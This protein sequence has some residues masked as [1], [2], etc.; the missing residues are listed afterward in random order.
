MDKPKFKMRTVIAAAIGIMSLFLVSCIYFIVG[1]RLTEL[2]ERDAIHNMSASLTAKKVVLENHITESEAFLT[3]YSRAGE[4][5]ELLKNP[6]DEK[7]FE[8]AQKYTETFSKDKEPHLEGIYASEWNTHVLTHTNRGTVGITTRK[9]EPLKQLQDAMLKANGVYNTGIII[10]PASQKQIIS[11]YRAVLDDAGNPIGLVGGGIF[12][13]GIKDVLNSMPSSGTESAKYYLLDR[14]SKKFIFHEDDNLVGSEV[15][16]GILANILGDGE[17]EPSGV[18]YYDGEIAVHNISSNGNWVFVMVDSEREVFSTA[19]TSRRLLGICCVVMAIILS[20]QATIGVPWLLKPIDYVTKA[21]SK[22]ASNDLSDDASLDKFAKR[23]SDIG[24]LARATVRVREALKDNVSSFINSSEEIK[25]K[26]LDLKESSTSLSEAVTD[27]GAST[28]ELYATSHSVTEA[29]SKVAEEVEVMSGNIATTVEFMQKSE[30]TSERLRDTANCMRQSALDAYHESIAKLEEVKSSANKAVEELSI[31]DSVNAMA[32]EVF[33]IASQTNLLSL[34]ASIEAA[35]A[36]EAGKG[37][38]VVAS[39]IKKLAD[40][41]SSTVAG[42]Q[43]LC[44]K[45]NKSVSDIEECIRNLCAFIEED[46]LVKLSKFADSSE[47]VTASVQ[48]IHEDIEHVGELIQKLNVSILGVSS[49]A[50]FVTEAMEENQR[51]IED[52]V[53]KNNTASNIASHNITESENNAALADV[54]GNIVE[55]FKL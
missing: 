1:A 35:R 8:A 34:N 4:I 26:A 32:D 39:E 43:E 20:I 12:T 28:E 25:N 24:V 7:A 29:A 47:D 51:A 13:S 46:V 2:V 18:H 37:F 38:S 42:I 52:I 19:I 33:S 15:K 48:D 22:V 41:C 16:E 36:G 3:A 40:A 14:A 50:T 6:T 30:G 27:I 23:S 11:M 49:S 31:F 9:D 53:E 5:T 17:L 44:N 54:L 21:L 10:S 45:S 55:G